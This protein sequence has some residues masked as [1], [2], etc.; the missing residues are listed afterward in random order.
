MFFIMGILNAQSKYITKTGVIDFEASVPSFEEVKAKNNKVSSILN[1]STGEIAALALVK[2]FR[3]KVAL[4]EEHFNENYAETE[5]FPKASFTG[6]I[7]DFSIDNLKKNDKT[8]ELTGKI[9]FHGKTVE[10]NEIASIHRD[11]DTIFLSTLFIISMAF[12]NHSTVPTSKPFVGSSNMIISLFLKT[13]LIN[14]SFF[15]SPPDKCS[16]SLPTFLFLLS[17]NHCS[18]PNRFAV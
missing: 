1:V 5:K 2:G 16:P 7:N 12:F 9:T 17:L 3:F 15:F 14:D 4:M 13:L 6:K 11:Q 8:F 18:I 10:I